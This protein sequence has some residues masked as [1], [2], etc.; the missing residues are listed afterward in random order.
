M[1]TLV[2]SVEEWKAIR[3][4]DLRDK[5]IGFVPT[6]GALHAGHQS[7][8]ARSMG[9]NDVTVASIFVNPTQFNNKDDFKT[10]PRNDESDLAMLSESG[11]QYAFYP[12]YDELYA[13]HYTYKITEHN[14]SLS[15]EGVG[16]PGH[17]DGV[18][19]VVMKLLNII[20]P[21]ASY[22]GEKDYQQY[23]LVSK[24]CEAFFI[25]TEIIL[26]PTVR[27]SDGL[28]LSS[29]NSLLSPENRKKASLFTVLLRSEKTPGIII[30]ELEEAGFKVDYICDH[31]GRRFGAVYLG[32]VRLIDNIELKSL[33]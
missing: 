16:R 20:G 3:N 10:Y 21:A 9:E 5:R 7:L 26:C 29:R 32:K 27:D 33:G 14:I 6:M 18:L 28:A 23:L 2:R 30:R 17:F 8:I 1:T 15:M 11:V 12:V 31:N 24:M 4:N 22:F 13:D 25:P 19:T